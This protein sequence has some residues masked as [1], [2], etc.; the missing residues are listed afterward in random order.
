MA[1]SKKSLFSQ[2]RE[3]IAEDTVD[4]NDA[5]IY[6]NLAR[7]PGPGARDYRKPKDTKGTLLRIL[8]YAGKSKKL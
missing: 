5:S 1:E 6:K 2:F 4:T 8:G 7:G 3:R